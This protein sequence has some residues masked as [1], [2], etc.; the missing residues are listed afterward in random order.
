[1]H[2]ICH[3]HESLEVWECYEQWD[4]GLEA[5]LTSHQRGVRL[6]V[7]QALQGPPQLFLPFT[8]KGKLTHNMALSPP[9]YHIK[10]CSHSWIP[11][12]RKWHPCLILDGL[13]HT[14][15]YRFD[16]NIEIL[17]ISYLPLYLFHT[18][19]IGF[20]VTKSVKINIHNMLQRR[21][22]IYMYSC[23]RH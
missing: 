5:L 17:W 21:H 2:W 11:S 8:T 3:P 12:I 10:F 14:I 7:W 6:R 1:M 20:R 22:F 4:G 13:F 16:T 15:W 23:K 9:K 18:T 19:K